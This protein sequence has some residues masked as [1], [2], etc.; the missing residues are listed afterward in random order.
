MNPIKTIISMFPFD[1]P[2]NVDLSYH[3][4]KHSKRVRKGKGMK[5]K[6]S[7]RRLNHITNKDHAKT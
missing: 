6:I 7:E 5:R 4:P 1:M 3:V 2:D